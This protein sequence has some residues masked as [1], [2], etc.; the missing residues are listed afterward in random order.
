M[1]P[2]NAPSIIERL[3]EAANKASRETGPS[4]A[5]RFVARVA[6]TLGDEL[7]ERIAAMTTRD[8][9]E[10]LRDV[11]PREQFVLVTQLYDALHTYALR[12]SAAASSTATRVSSIN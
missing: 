8:Q 10:A 9:L 1:K 11:L 2:F 12:A 4:L 5:R 7:V 6:A 3:R